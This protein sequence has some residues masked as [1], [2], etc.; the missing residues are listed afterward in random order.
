MANEVE[1]LKAAGVPECDA[2]AIHAEAQKQN[3]S[4]LALWR[5]MPMILSFIGMLKKP[6]V[7]WAELV[8]AA[9]EIAAALGITLPGSPT[10]VPPGVPPV[11]PGPFAVKAP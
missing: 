4:W 9:L 3:I 1:Q 10:A 6:G 2:Q 11:S 5:V 7:T 8:T